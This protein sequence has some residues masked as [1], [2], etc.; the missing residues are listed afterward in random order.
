MLMYK[1]AQFL[2]C[3]S[4]FWCASVLEEREVSHTCPLCHGTMLESIP[5]ASNE[6]YRFDHNL[7]RGIV[8][9]FMA[10]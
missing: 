1:R 6:S 3:D 8:L 5:I 7:E 2:I 4:C 10:G 9:E